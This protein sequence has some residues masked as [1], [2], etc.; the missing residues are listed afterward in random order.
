MVDVQWSP[1]AARDYWVAS[2][3]NHRCLVWN[4]NLREDS[5]TG[6]IEHSLQGHSRAI[7]DINF[8]AHHPD[9]LATCAVD[10]YVHSW[11]LRRPR[12]PVLTFCDWLAG[13]TQVKYNRQDPNILASSHDRWLH[14]WDERKPS[15]PLK[16]FSAHTSKIYGL[17][18]NRTSSTAVVTCSLDKSIKIWDYEMSDEPRRIIRTD[19]P[20]WRARYTPFGRGLLAMS[21]NDPG[22]LYLYDRQLGPD[23]PRDGPVEPVKVFTGSPNHKAKEF[24]WRARG[25]ITDQGIDER[26]F[27]LVSWGEDN[28]LRLHR[29][30]PEILESVGHVK[31]ALAQQKYNVTRKGATYKTFRTVDANVGSQRRSATMSDPRPGSGGGQYRRSLPMSTSNYSR[32]GTAQAWRGPSMKARSASGKHSD[33]NRDQLGWM[34]GIMMSRKKTSGLLDT[35]LRKDSKDSSLFG[36]GFHDNQWGDPETLQE[37]II[38]ISQQFPNVNW[39]NVDMDKLTLKASL[40]GPWGADGSIIYVTVHVDI[41]HDYPNSK[42]PKFL[43]EKQA[44][45]PDQTYKKLDREVQQLANQ[46]SK[47]RQNCLEVIFS[48]FLGETDLSNSD[49]FFKNVKDLDDELDGLADESS[50]EDDDEIPV[51]GSITMSQELSAST[52]LDA[53]LA[54]ANR[55]AI[56]SNPCKCGARWSNDGRLVCFFPSKEEKAKDLFGPSDSYRDRSKDEPTFAGFGRLQPDSTP[57]RRRYMNDENS[58]TEDQSDSDE[59]HNSSTSSSDSETTYMHKINMWYLPGRRFRKTFSGSLSLHSS[60]GGTGIGTGTG[61]GTSRRR[62]ARPKNVIAIHNFARELPSQK[63][64]AQEY[65]IFGDGVEVCDHN[66]RVA[67]KYG[68]P[69]LVD[70]WEYAALILRKDIPLELMGHDAHNKSIL[71]IAK[72]AVA[73]FRDERFGVDNSGDH[74]ITGRVKWGEHPLG[75]AMVHNIFEY[76]EKIADVQMLAMLS[77]IFNE[78]TTAEAT[79]AVT[80]SHYSLPETPLAVKAPA[81]SLDYFPTDI[82]LWP[83]SSKPHYNSVVSTPKTA[84]TPLHPVAGSYGSDGAWTGDP[85]SQS[86]SCGETPPS[87]TPRERLSDGDPTQ[88]LSTSPNNR[89]LQRASTALSSASGF[90][91]SF[92]RPFAQVSSTSPPGRKRTSPGDNFLTNLAPSN[93][94]WGGS[95]VLGPTSE[96]SATARNSLSDDDARREGHLPLVCYGISA[97]VE[98]QSIFDDD[99]WLATP[100][101][102][103]SC[104]AIYTCYR[105]AYAEML[106]MWGQPLARLEIMK[107]NVLKQDPLGATP[108]PF[109]SWS[110]RGDTYRDSYN[111]ADSISHASQSYHDGTATGA[112]SAQIVLGKKE[113]LQ[114]VIASGRGLDVTGI[115]R[116]HETHLEPMQT[117]HPS[118]RSGGAAGTCERCHYAQTQ[119]SCVYCREPIDSLYVPCL[120][121]GCA[122]HD[123]CLAEW[124]AAASEEGEDGTGSDVEWECPAGD[125]CR[126][127]DVAC[128]GQIES[129]AVLMGMLRQGKVSAPPLSGA[130]T[131][132]GRGRPGHGH[133][134]SA[135]GRFFFYVEDEDDRDRDRNGWEKVDKPPLRSFAALD[136]YDDVGADGRPLGRSQSQLPLSSATAATAAAAAARFNLSSRL[137]KSAGQWGSTTSLRKKSVGSSALSR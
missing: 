111:S 28:E 73:R 136:A 130:A 3:A 9:I 83:P 21:Q 127:I 137:R 30:E 51:G 18:W 22:H 64:F 34:K 57:P 71:V 92:P 36:P 62:A 13:A 4:L 104:D 31:G 42:A 55:F 17:D 75:R 132:V 90:A 102:E 8:S 80:E 120:S 100:L 110:A 37:E 6:A 99:G 33:R 24:L 77:C 122:A 29:M 61:T 35:P 32:P 94:T 128:E 124:Y 78:S 5:A 20:V 113:Q 105:H 39:D 48:Y 135:G 109:G 85:E 70:V 89:L 133:S 112:G 11:D 82:A 98:D 91:A 10:G 59:S 44:M 7:T 53:T 45:M 52:E 87:R 2:T 63:E 116:V 40:D 97:E 41:P 114:A 25:G 96:P 26:E 86:Y 74:I 38:R 101:L 58:M 50:S 67:E 117:T 46:F 1:F 103:P 60:G 54:P 14:I 118:A 23:E 84:H 115:C 15:I 69:D 88:S 126:C 106:Q 121:C 119:L 134:T 56:P 107:F 81:F 16:S 123:A 12:Q 49:S 93:I 79:T 27:Q 108:D 66:A 43:I 125:E 68:R 19:F 47:R 65:L 131:G 95:M 129:F 76:F 72:D